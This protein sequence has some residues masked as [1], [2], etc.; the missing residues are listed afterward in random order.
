V[1]CV[2]INIKNTGPREAAVTPQLYLE[3][4]EE[5]GYPAPVLKGFSKHTIQVGTTKTITFP[6]AWRDV[7]YW[8]DD[9]YMMV[10]VL[11]A[12]IGAS[13]A[14]IQASITL[15]MNTFVVNV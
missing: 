15:T 10:D 12:H 4:P 11:N 14:D 5:A 6:L 7:S 2:S 8:E 13:S 1:T 9:K 3:F